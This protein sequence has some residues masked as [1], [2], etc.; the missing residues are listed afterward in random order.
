M[1]RTLFYYIFFILVSSILFA[2]RDAV[3][4]NTIPGFHI[5][6]S[7]VVFLVLFVFLIAL[8]AF[9][10]LLFLLLFINSQ[11]GVIKI[12]LTNVSVMI[13]I[14]VLGLIYWKIAVQKEDFLVFL[15]CFGPVALLV[16][17]L[18]LVQERLKER[19]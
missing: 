15:W 4:I 12:L 11:F 13:F 9:S 16:F 5:G 19:D 17:N 18:Q 7:D 2:V 10:P 3:A 6:I 14:F 8:V 1:K